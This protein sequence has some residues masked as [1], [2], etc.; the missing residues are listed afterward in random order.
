[1][2][3]MMFGIKVGGGGIWEAIGRS[4]GRK[5]WEAIGR[6]AGLASEDALSRELSV[7]GVIPN[8]AGSCG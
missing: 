1:M 5:G 3:G 7:G 2:H 4:G 8:F 6:M